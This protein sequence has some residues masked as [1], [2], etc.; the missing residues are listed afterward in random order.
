MNRWLIALVFAGFV[1]LE[2]VFPN[3]PGAAINGGEPP[4]AV[5]TAADP[6]AEV[7]HGG[8]VGD[9]KRVLR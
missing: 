2:F 6:G 8:V 5:T 3:E 1:A 7:R 4:L 9:A